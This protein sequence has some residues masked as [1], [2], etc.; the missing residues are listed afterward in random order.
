MFDDLALARAAVDELT[1][2]FRHLERLALL[3]S[4]HLDVVGVGD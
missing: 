3:R 4:I 2:N 1:F